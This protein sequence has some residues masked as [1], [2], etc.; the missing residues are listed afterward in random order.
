MQ[1]G[2]LHCLL[3]MNDVKKEERRIKKEEK[4][5]DAMSMVDVDTFYQ[6]ERSDFLIL[7]FFF[8]FEW[9]P[10]RRLCGERGS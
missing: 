2:G 8:A 4:K 3:R 7:F 6:S 5:G 10:R 1:P 9:I